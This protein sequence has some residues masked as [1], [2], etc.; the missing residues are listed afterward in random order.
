ML[1]ISKGIALS[2]EPG[3]GSLTLPGFIRDV[4]TRFAQR[5]AL[6]LHMPNA[7]MRWTYALL[8]DR[9]VQIAR[10]LIACGVGKDTRVG[11]LMTNRPEWVAAFFGVGLAGGVA[12]ALSTFS[13][14]P[15]LEYLLQATNVSMLLLERSVAKK[16]FV[17]MLCELEPAIRAAPPGE[18]V[19]MRFPFLRRLVAVD[20]NGGIAGIETWA[21]FLAHGDAI[22]ATLVEA[23]AASVKPADTAA[24]FL[25]SGST[26]RPKGIL[27]SHRGVAKNR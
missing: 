13:T 20:D 26:S 8:W 27:S 24:L 3:I 2:E 18:L 5:E 22:P 12:V 1:S 9:A 15:E 25:S 19:S 11:I 14:V 16:D 21:D 4:T 17:Q 23:T 7:V 10:T 6:V